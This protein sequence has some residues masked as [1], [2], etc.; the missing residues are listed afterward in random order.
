MTH[1]V[2]ISYSHR[3]KKTA[4]AVCL[5]LE[6]LGVGCWIS[7]RDIKTGQIWA[8]AIIEAINHSRIMVVVFSSFSNNSQQVWR[9]IE[10]AVNREIPIITLRV[11]NVELSD[12]MAYYLSLAHW[13]DAI[14]PPFRKHLQQLTIRVKSLLETENSDT[15]AWK[16]A[17]E[18]PKTPILRIQNKWKIGLGLLVLVA[19]FIVGLN[20]FQSRNLAGIYLPSENIAFVSDG[21]IYITNPNGTDKTGLTE[22]YNPIWSPD[23]KKIA[24][25]N[26]G[27]C[28]IN[29]DGTGETQIVDET[30]IPDIWNMQQFSWSP[31]GEK[32]LIALACLVVPPPTGKGNIYTVNVDGRNLTKLAT[33][34]SPGALFS[35]DGKKITYLLGE[36]PNQLDTIYLN[37][38]L[39]DGTA[40]SR[41][42][43]NKLVINWTPY[44]AFSLSSDGGKMT[45]GDKNGFYVINSDGSGPIKLLDSA[46]GVEP[47][48]SPDGKL[49]VYG[50]DNGLFIV[51]SDGT[52]KIEIMQGNTCSSPSWS[53]DGKRII[54]DTD[55]KG[56]IFIVN[57]DGNNLSKVVS[58]HS[59]HWSPA[60]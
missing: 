5:A 50:N 31:N 19:F 45:F 3:N 58:G 29:I 9:E 22:G 17:R 30:V 42:I 32:L 33:G 38:M 28:V 4:D 21:Y 52:G 6:K 13:L 37:T 16:P 12:T 1:D 7:H 18:K 10:R 11:E 49:L 36:V 25:S 23:G 20:I 59:P 26:A 55:T 27:L 40:K 46:Y 54:F 34:S 43:D 39:P 14:S 57:A 44:A 53:P 47:A 56:D 15:P 8:E 41:L 24:Y 35:P 2:F 60:E 48:W 51:N